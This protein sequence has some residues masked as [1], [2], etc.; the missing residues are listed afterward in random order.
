MLIAQ[1]TDFHI[2]PEGHQLYGGI[3]TN[4]MT[5]RAVARLAELDPA[6]DCVVITGDLADCGR[7][8]EYALVSEILSKLAM[9]VFAVPGNHDRR[10]PM[11]TGLAEVCG[12]LRRADDF[13]N[14]IVEGFPVRLIGLDTNMPGEDGGAVCAAREEW[15]AHHLAEG[16]GRPTILFM[17][18]P[19]FV[20]GV[21]GMDAMMCRTRPS[22]ARL[23]ESHPEI[24]RIACG[25]YH[26][27]IVRRWA[28]TLGLVAPGVAHQVALDLRPGE[29]NRFILEPPGVALHAWTADAGLISHFLPL[30]DFGPSRDFDLDPDYPGQGS[31]Q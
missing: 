20:T 18:H 1:I 21:S 23:I 26:R 25:H 9:P 14:F 19:P 16:D 3:D 12:H 10:E 29:P 8:E 17:H 30:G 6:P 31:A 5:R 15:L 22:F 24:E 28:G 4:A 27:P 2:R 7:P 11:R 13:L